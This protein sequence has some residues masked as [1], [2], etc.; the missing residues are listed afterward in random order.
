[1]NSMNTVTYNFTII[2]YILF[3]I[4]GIFYLRNILQS[5][6]E[7]IVLFVIFSNLLYILLHELGHV[8]VG[9]LLSFKLLECNI[10]F[11]SIK[12][13]ILTSKFTIKVNF[14]KF[15][16]FNGSTYMNLTKLDN[17]KLTQFYFLSEGIIFNVVSIFIAIFI[18]TNNF[19]FDS[20]S[21]EFFIVFCYISLFL[22]LI[23]ILAVHPSENLPDGSKIF[24]LFH[25][26]SFFNSLFIDCLDIQ[27]LR[28]REWIQY[29]VFSS[30]TEDEENDFQVTLKL[31]EFLSSIDSKNFKRSN[32]IIEELTLLIKY[33]S[34][35]VHDSVLTTIAVYH[36]LFK[37][38]HNQAFK[39]F[40]NLKNKFKS[41]TLNIL[42]LKIFLSKENDLLVEFNE[43]YDLLSNY[44][45][46]S[47]HRGT[48]EF[49]TESLKTLNFQD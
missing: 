33:T 8:L 49:Y 13:N 28:P 11:F 35:A 10:W 21:H 7:S 9:Y 24:N 37:N 40:S 39:Y 42:F 48:S 16:S 31:Y 17:F 1:M 22:V 38:E 27:G 14:Y 18:F 29:N 2:I 44:F 15:L 32:Q 41:S 3:N 6:L 45:K 46:N 19:I 36:Y 20:S 43:N 30:L 34:V 23:N 5:D 25:S 12:K 26:I 4:I 47:Y